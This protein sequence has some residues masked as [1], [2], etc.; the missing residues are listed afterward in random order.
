MYPRTLTGLVIFLLL[1]LGPDAT[2]AAEDTEAQEAVVLEIIEEETALREAAGEQIAPV[3]E[4]EGAPVP[5]RPAQRARY[6]YRRGLE[7]YDSGDWKGAIANLDQVV[8]INPSYRRA[9]YYRREAWNLA[10]ASVPAGAEAEILV[11]D[12]R[13][14]FE[15]GRASLRAEDYAAAVVSFQTVLQVN[16]SHREARNL[17]GEARLKLEKRSLAEEESLAQELV[18]EEIEL[19]QTAQSEEDEALRR[20]YDEGRTALERG[21]LEAAEASFT[22]IRRKRGDYRRGD[23]FLRRIDREIQAKHEADLALSDREAIRQYTLGPDDVVRVVV[24]NHPEF[25]F[26]A[27]IEEGGEL[28]IPL[29][30][31]IIQAD[32]LTRDE[33]AEL[34]RQRIAAYIDDPF[35]KVFIT[36]YGSKKFYVLQPEGGGS[37]YIMSKA[38]MTLWDCMFLAGIPMLDDAALRRIQVIP[39]HPTHPTHRWI[40][41]YAM[42]YQGKMKDNIRIEPGTIIYYPMLVIDKFSMIVEKITKPISDLASLGSS[43]EEWD[44]FRKKYLR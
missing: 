29:T 44:S 10:A 18:K 7:A 28:V 11:E 2:R 30:N 21:E 8:A 27:R 15:R 12:L 31:E 33:L 34:L 22:E 24:R 14:E 5:A 17:L 3:P 6:F 37:E 13:A 41:V 9:D 1:G 42:L 19:R 40:N 32:G 35:V 38:N 4:E 20:A 36:N 25:S 39:P 23:Y 26:G 43:Y 16:P